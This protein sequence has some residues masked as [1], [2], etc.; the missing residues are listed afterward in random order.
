MD[1]NA[2]PGGTTMQDFLP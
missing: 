2:K 1:Q